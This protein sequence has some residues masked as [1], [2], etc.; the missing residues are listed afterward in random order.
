M[1]EFDILMAQQLCLNGHMSTAHLITPTHTKVYS[2]LFQ[3]YNLT[4]HIHQIIVLTCADENILFH[5]KKQMR[6]G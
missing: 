3:Q 4:N 5:G 6:V 1:R 2:M